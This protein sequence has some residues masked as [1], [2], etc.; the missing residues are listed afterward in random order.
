MHYLNDLRNRLTFSHFN[1]FLM[2][3]RNRLTFSHFIPLPKMYYKSIN[4]FTFYFITEDALGKQLTLDE[5]IIWTFQSYFPCLT[6][7]KRSYLIFS[8]I[9]L[10]LFCVALFTYKDPSQSNM[11]NNEDG[12][13]KTNDNNDNKVQLT[14]DMWIENLQG[15]DC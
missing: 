10:L 3:H 11:Y 15:L 7:D 13:I 2:N 5:L 14:N 4:F 6:H 9:N 12:L 1:L 8:V